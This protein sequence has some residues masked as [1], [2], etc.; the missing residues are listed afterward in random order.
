MAITEHGNQ[1][2]SR[3]SLLT[4]LL[5]NVCEVVFVRRHRP[6]PGR[7]KPIVESRRMLC[8]NSYSLLRSFYGLRYLG[9]RPFQNPPPFDPRAKNIVITWDL[10]MID[11]RC[12]PMEQCYLV[13]SITADQAFWDV[14]VNKYSKMS[15]AQKSIFMDN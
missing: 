4:I 9:Y 12:I 15:S 1:L 5:T 14:F 11:Y 7:I 8:T 6:V 10:F 3:S 13:R 2:I